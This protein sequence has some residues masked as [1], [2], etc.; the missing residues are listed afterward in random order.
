MIIDGGAR[1]NFN[2]AS[3][4]QKFAEGVASVSDQLTEQR[5]P[6]SSLEW[7]SRDGSRRSQIEV[8]TIRLYGLDYKGCSRVWPVK[9]R[10][11]HSMQA[12]G[13]QRIY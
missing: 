1:K 2:T 10:A 7:P 3:M 11:M 12:G 8:K 4:L 13:W 6:S 5:E 9:S